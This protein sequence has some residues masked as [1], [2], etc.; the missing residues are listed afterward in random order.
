MDP[1]S[2]IVTAVAGLGTSIANLFTAGKN[3][4][5]GRLPDWLSPRDFQKND[6]TLEIALAVIGVVLI[7]VIIAITRSVKK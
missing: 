2:A 7:V 1:V 5:Y 3:A 6:R 4:K